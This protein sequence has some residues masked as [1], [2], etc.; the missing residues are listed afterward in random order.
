MIIKCTYNFHLEVHLVFMIVLSQYIF[1]IFEI[2]WYFCSRFKNFQSSII[3][4]TTM[5]K[6]NKNKQDQF[7]NVEQ[8]LSAS[9]AFIE[10][11]Q[12]EIMYTVIGIAVLVMVF[13]AVSNYIVKPRSAT[14]AHEMYKAQQYFERDSFQLALQGDDFEAIGLEAI[15][16]K[17][18]FTASGNLAKAYAGIAHYN[19][20]NYEDAIHYLSAYDG[21]DNYLAATTIGLIGDCYI[22]L[23]QT[24][25]SIKYFTKAAGFD[26]EVTA[27]IFLKKAAMA[28]EA[29]GD[30]KKALKNFIEIKE[31]YPMSHEARD[32]DK[33][34]TRLQ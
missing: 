7:E 30:T 12:K 19:L 9:E 23:D 8:A 3:S 18:R 29:T 4:N 28:L 11:Y 31:K 15:S 33:Y 20:G 32:I 26:N 22:Q 6:K 16:S 14:A 27:P 1:F 17:Y 25:K 5:S 13:L 24:A 10:K 21:S 2:N 34:I